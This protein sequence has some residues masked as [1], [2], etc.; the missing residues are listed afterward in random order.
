MLPVFPKQNYMY[1]VNKS[2][3]GE[4]KEKDKSCRVS[5]SNSG[6]VY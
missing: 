1:V 2:K 5:L 4:K 6:C 3:L